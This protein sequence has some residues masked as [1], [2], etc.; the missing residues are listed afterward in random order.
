MRQAEILIKILKRNIKNLSQTIQSKRVGIF[1][2]GGIDSSIIAT[3]ANEIFP[4]LS[5]ITLH[6]PKAQD[7]P[8]AGKLAEFLGKELIIA[9]T[10]KNKLEKIR[11]RLEKILRKN[12]IK[13]AAVHLPIAASF[14][15]LCE[16]AS[17]IG[18][19][20]ILTGQ[21]PDILFAGYAKYKNL[22][23]AKLNSAI[24][25]DLPL[26]QIDEIRDNSV[27]KEF[28]INL[29]NPYLEENIIHFALKLPPELKINQDQD[30]YILRQAAEILQ[31]PRE[32]ISRR[33]KAIQ[34]SSRIAKLI[35]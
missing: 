31:I 17:E 28:R 10:D 22:P 11:P 21:G 15:T 18:M 29:H 33:K 2:S 9:K 23:L 8:F 13:P 34:Y 16:K 35:G 4:E 25:K 3:L 24:Q 12:K 7:L 6:T 19:T 20:D 5:L 1:L 30:K 32:I 14:F 27:A 26:L